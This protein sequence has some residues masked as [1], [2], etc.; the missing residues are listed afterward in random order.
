MA[1]ALTNLPRDDA[2]TGANSEP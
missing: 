1:R 2:P